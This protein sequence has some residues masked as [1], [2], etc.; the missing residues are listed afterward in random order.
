MTTIQAAGYIV[1]N[2]EAIWG[3]GKTAD[4]AWA[5]FLRGMSEARVTVL[6]PSEDMPEEG[7]SYT[8]ADDYQIKPATTALLAEIEGK[9]GNIGWRMRGG[10]ACTRDEAEA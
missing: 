9:G 5:D 2:N 10:V 4:E 8:R 1:T 6:L 3:T 7:G